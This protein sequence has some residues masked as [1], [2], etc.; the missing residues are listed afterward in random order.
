MRKF[1]VGLVKYKKGRKRRAKKANMILMLILVGTALV[2][3]LGFHALSENSYNENN[4]QSSQNEIAVEHR[5]FINKLAPQAQRLQ[6]QYNIL[7]SITL[8]QAILESDW[9]TSKL[10][11]KYYNLFGVKAQDG[12]T[13]SVY[14]NTQEFVNGRYVTVKARF[15]VYQNWNES[16]ADHAKLLAYGTKWNSQ[17]YKDV[18]SA[19]NYL[20]A[21]DGLQQDGYATDPTYTKKLIS[22]IRQYKLYQYDD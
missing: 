4:L 13:N 16:L 7:P 18:V 11:S 2:I 3:I 19:T 14:L 8:A 21:A 9:G 20:Q 6:G 1:E 10:A 5:K 12:S 22:L 15:Q 17:Q